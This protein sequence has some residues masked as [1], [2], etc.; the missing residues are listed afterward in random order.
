VK[1]IGYVRVS[2]R[3]Q[4]ESGLGLADQRLR[5]EEACAA[6]DWVLDR[7]EADEGVSGRSVDKR[8]GLRSA[9]RSLAAGGADALVAVKIDRLSRSMADF[10]VIA[11][12]AVDQ[13][14]VLLALDVDVDSA[15]PTGELIVT[16]MAALAQFESRLIGERTSRALAEARRR[17]TRLGR[18]VDVPEEVAR[19]IVRRIDAGAT[20]GQVGR[21]LEAEGVP[22]ARGGARWWPATIR[23]VY[24]R[25][26]EEVD[27]RSIPQ[28]ALQ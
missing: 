1:A 4:A 14:W 21:E 15:T 24:D 20:A 11:K 13:G 27:V 18:P 6:R 28:E 26:T 19:R 25:M 2:K 16:I 7:I 12:T 5:I 17:G 10:A 22:T 8:P 9:M 23:A 3:E